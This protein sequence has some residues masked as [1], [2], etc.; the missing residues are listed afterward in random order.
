MALFLGLTLENRYPF[1][2][3]KN[4]VDKILEEQRKGALFGKI[5]LKNQEKILKFTFFAIF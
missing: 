5:I 2:F 3:L 4:C 1:E